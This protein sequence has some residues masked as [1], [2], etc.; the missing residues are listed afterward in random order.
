MQKYSE[1]AQYYNKV[2]SENETLVAK[3]GRIMK[4]LTLVRLF[5]FISIFAA[6]FTFKNTNLTFA[7]ACTVFFLVVFLVSVVRFQRTKRS[8]EYH[9]AIVDICN[10]EEGALNHD[11]S[12]FKDGREFI[13]HR[14]PFT[15]DLDVF[16]V[17]SLYQFLNRTSLHPGS[18]KLAGKLKDNE[19]DHKKITQLQSSIKELSGKNDFCIKFRANGALISEVQQEYEKLNNWIKAPFPLKNRK[20]FKVISLVLPAITVGT[21]ILAAFISAF[22]GIAV[23]F[24]LLNLFIV[25]VSLKKINAYNASLSSVIKLMTKYH[26][27]L[28]L[29]EKENWE[30]EYNRKL[31][32][33]L[34]IKLNYASVAIA[35]LNR[36]VNSFDQRMNVIVAI[37][38]E[39]FL[40]W[41]FHFIEKIERWKEVYGRHFPDWMDVLAEYDAAI[42]L[43]TCAFNNSDFVYPEINS[44]VVFSAKKLAHP[45]ISPSGRVD[46]DFD[47]SK[48]GDFTIITGANMS[49][50]STFLRTV[51]INM[52]LAGTGMP[53]CASE[54]IFKPMSLYTSMRTSD[55]LAQNESYFYAELLRLKVLLELLGDDSNVFIILDE[56][57][58][59]TNSHDKQKGSRM[60][61]EKILKMQGTGIIATHDLELTQIEKDY[62]QNIS[63]QCF[64]IEI[65]DA[66]IN[67]DYKL[68]NGVTQ[69]MNAILLMKQMGIV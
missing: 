68:Q 63:N 13:D 66:E 31:C 50:K 26:K 69:K 1:P 46:N 53:I 7:I 54:L 58:K 24:F 55:S 14:H 17:R 37:V 16:G 9:Q 41:D 10:L 67:F 61:L 11:Y 45:L 28:L 33:S 22:Q 39:G 6:F 25:S 15:Y 23:L 18:I 62:P 43:A 59:G 27:L 12:K 38:L 65:D 3:L 2:K 51:A 52:I 49:G 21:A 32:D 29:V 48:K 5:T 35:K 8:K 44:E 47:L 30:S 60:V 34:Q 4:S 57:L 64:E 36:Y 56:I 20:V 19:T 40:L 42:S